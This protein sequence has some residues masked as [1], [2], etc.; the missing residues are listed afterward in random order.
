ML[1]RKPSKLPVWSRLKRISRGS[2]SLREDSF[3]FL[4][5]SSLKILAAENNSISIACC[6]IPCNPDVVE[7]NKEGLCRVSENPVACF[8]VKCGWRMTGHRRLW[9]LEDSAE[10]QIICPWPLSWHKQ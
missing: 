5:I 2:A 10:D 4:F 8:S 3:W 1:G 9:S 7:K 6:S